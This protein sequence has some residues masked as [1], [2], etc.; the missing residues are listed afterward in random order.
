MP[1]INGT[2]GNDSIDVS[3]DSGTLNGAPQGSPIN[4]IRA[5]GGNDVVT[6][7]NRMS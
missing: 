1:N 6:V 7:S 3:N 2:T 5:R 4:D